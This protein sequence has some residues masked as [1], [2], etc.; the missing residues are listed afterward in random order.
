MRCT[1]IISCLNAYVDGE[2]S[3]RQQRVVK[4]HLAS[5][6]SCRELLEDMQNL[7]ELFKGTLPVPPIPNDFATRIMAEARRRQPV[8]IP[9]SPS[10]LPA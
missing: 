7:A 2:L 9:G 6:E 5:C 4:A 1:K 3:R 10:P 8:E